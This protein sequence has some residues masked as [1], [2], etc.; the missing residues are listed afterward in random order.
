MAERVD[1]IVIGAGVV[2][3]AIARS[4]ALA[5]R[6]VMVLEASN[7]I[8]TGTSSRNSEV[9]HAGIYY[10]PGSLK[11][12]LCVAGRCLLY[13]YAAERGI[14][15]RAVGKLIV[16]TDATQLPKLKALRETAARNGVD[17]LRWIDSHEV[18]ALEPEVRSVGALYSPSSGIVDSHGLM[19]ALQGDIETAG[20]M[21]AFNAPVAGG[22]VMSGGIRLVTGGADPVTLDCALVVNA[23]GLAAPALARSITGLSPNSV[24]KAYFAK[25]N[26]FALSGVRSPFSHLIYP[27]PEQ[28]GLGVHATIDL[29]GQT[30]FGPD[31]E[32]IDTIDYSV[33]P[34][35]AALFYDAIRRFWPA[36]PDQAL[37]PSYCGIRPKLS[38]EGQPAA[39]FLIQGP[40]QHGAPGLVNLYGIESPGLTSSLAIA[41]LVTKLTDAVTLA[42]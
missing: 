4:L 9:V 29:G 30:K 42:A 16:A 41:E 2:G 24:P 28:V 39:D 1:A 22:E 12:R 35:R 8:G 5:G 7:A 27:M 37:V 13:S 14:E 10:A 40:S 31:V 20:G 33:D 23:A 17:D 11:A 32:W 15:A 36:L 38:G 19:L 34:S 3:L 21:V 18:A 6:E 25:G 26:Y